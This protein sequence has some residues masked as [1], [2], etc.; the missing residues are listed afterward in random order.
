MNTHVNFIEQVDA[1]PGSYPTFKVAYGEKTTHLARTPTGGWLY[2]GMES[3]VPD[4][5]PDELYMNDKYLEERCQLFLEWR[6]ADFDH[7]ADI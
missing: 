4:C 1:W 3:N 5:I 2:R 7:N 6:A